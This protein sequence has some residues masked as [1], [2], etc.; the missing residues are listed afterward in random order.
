M[1]V[2]LFKKGA[3]HTGK[4][5]RHRPAAFEGMMAFLKH[6]GLMHGVIQLDRKA[7]DKKNQGEPI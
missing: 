2:A 6:D 5:V 1:K 3:S 7:K 4:N